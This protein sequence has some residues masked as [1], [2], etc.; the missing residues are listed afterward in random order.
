MPAELEVSKAH[1]GGGPE[2]LTADLLLQTQSLKADL[3]QK[4]A[5]LGA[6]IEANERLQRE[7]A[8]V[9]GLRAELLALPDVWPRLVPT[10]GRPGRV[11]ADVLARKNGAM[12]PVAYSGAP[13]AYPAARLHQGTTVRGAVVVFGDVANE[14]AE[15][16]RAKRRVNGLGWVGRIRDA[17]DEHRLALYSQPIVPLSTSGP[18][19]G[20]LLLRMIG[21]NGEVILPGSFLPVAERYGQIWEIDQWVISQ[22]A[23]VAASGRR[24]YANLSAASVGRV[25]LLVEIERALRESGAKPSNVVF[26]ITETALMVNLDAGEALARRLSEMGCGLALD[27]FGTGYGSFTYLQ[28]LPFTYLKI[29]TSFVHDLASSQASQRV[30]RA[31]VTIAHEFGQQTIAEGVEDRLTLDLLRD[32]GV[33]LAQG[34]HLGRPQPLQLA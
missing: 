1:T 12:F 11:A 18:R 17:L 19:S 7:L 24:V 26:E 5:E 13:A 33:D 10:V 23:V 2:S 34:F 22:A 21:P 31:I 29:D 8:D 4:V 30:V 32:Y 16:T 27:D 25:D 3:M 14:H 20:E 15:R 28:K 6:L 9:Q